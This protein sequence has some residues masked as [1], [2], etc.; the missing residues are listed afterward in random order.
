[1]KVHNRT[2]GGGARPGWAGPVQESDM[3]SVTPEGRRRRL[4]QVGGLVLPMQRPL[5]MPSGHGSSLGLPDLAAHILH[6]DRG[7]DLIKQ[8]S[9]ASHRLHL[10][11]QDMMEW[12]HAR[13]DSDLPRAGIPP[14]A[15]HL[16][17]SAD[18]SDPPSDTRARPASVRGALTKVFPVFD[19]SG[20]RV[21]MKPAGPAAQLRI[22]PQTVN[23][24]RDPRTL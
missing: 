22:T 17:L 21:K 19:A 16:M 18:L 3:T 1:M 24:S 4:V 23:W 14:H 15:L 20:T 7:R 9:C 5:G 12:A 10:A 13:R 6:P 2:P 8:W 11:A